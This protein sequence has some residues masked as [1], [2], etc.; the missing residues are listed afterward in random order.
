MYGPDPDRR[1]DG[2]QSQCRALHYSASRGKN[3]AFWCILKGSE[4]LYAQRMCY[5]HEHG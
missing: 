5:D 3:S 2:M 1:T 4:R